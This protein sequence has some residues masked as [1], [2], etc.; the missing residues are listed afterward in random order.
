[1][2]LDTVDLVIAFEERLDLD[3]PN[4]DAA[5]L[6]TPHMVIDYLCTRLPT[7]DSPSHGGAVAHGSREEI[8]RRVVEVIET[9][10]GVDMGKFTLDSY[11]VKDM[12]L[13]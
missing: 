11:F 6:E 4:D 10:T 7:T 9:E 3:I 1:M 5:R 8:E 13:D 2:G 12:G